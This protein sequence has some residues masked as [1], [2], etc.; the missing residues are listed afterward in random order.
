MRN[1]CY[2][3]PVK[4]EYKNS[5][6]GTIQDYSASMQ[7]VYIEPEAV[8]TLMRE[9]NILYHEE[10]DEIEKIPFGIINVMLFN[11]LANRI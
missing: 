3:L 11:K 8:A 2:C 6:R 9:K 1:D 5:I 7:T 10:H 4:S